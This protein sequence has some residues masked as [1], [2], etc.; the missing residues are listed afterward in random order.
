MDQQIRAHLET[1]EAAPGDA[2]AFQAL[3]EAF[4]KGG[5]FDEL[6]S[7]L[8]AR[9]RVLPAAG[10]AQ[11]LAQA[12]GVALRN[13]ANP[14]RA[15]EL[16]RGLLALD[17]VS[18]PALL[19]LAELAEARQDWAA[20]AEALERRVPLTTDPG[21]SARL[22][23][24]L[25]VIYEER[26]GRRDRAAM[27]F[28]GAVRL[29]AG[30]VEARQRGLEACLGLRRY[31]QAKRLLDTARD[32]GAE[33]PALARDYVRLGATLADQ[34]LFHDVAMDALIEA[35]AIDR[36]T[37]GAAEARERLTALPRRWREEAAALEAAAAAAPRKE[38]A[39]LLLRTAQ[40]QAA[41]APDGVGPAVDLLERAWA[42]APGQPAV[43]ELLERVL[44]E[45]K[46]YG[47]QAAALE[48]LAA[49]TRDRGALVQ[50][51]LAASRLKLVRLGDGAGALAALAR[52]L[53]LDPAC[54]TAALQSFE[55]LADAGR[56]AEA[57][58]VLERHLEATPEKPGHALLRVRAAD[59][60]RSRLGDPARARRHLE[61]A[62][63]A[64]P[65]HAPAAAALVPLLTEGEEWARLAE[66][67]AV[68][69]AGEPD[70]AARVRLQEQLAAVEVER[71]DRPADAFR[72]LSRALTL[73]PHRGSVRSAL[74][75]AARR[76][77]LLPE[78]CR[79]LRAAAMAVG[80]DGP[81][82]RALMQ[83][84]AEL[85]EQELGQPEA[86]AAAW[87]ELA[88][89]DPSDSEVA[90]AVAECET[91]LRA[92]LEELVTLEA[93]HAAATGAARRQTG[94]AL[95]SRLTAAGRGAAAATVWRE[96]QAA[97]ADAADDAESLWGLHA[98][99]EATPGAVAAEERT[100]VLARLAALARG[101]PER[102]QLELER[103]AILVD[104]LGR[105]GEAA[106]VVTGLLSAGGATAQQQQLAVSLLER[107]LARGV[108]PLR[109]ARVLAP[110][111]AAR[112]DARRQVAMLE[113]VARRLPADADP[114]ERARHL[115]DA[116]S[117]RA[118][119]MGDARGALTAAAEALR[120]APNHPEARKRCEQLAHQVGAQAE[121]YAL[122]VAAARQLAGRPD[123]ELVLRRRAAAVAE[124]ELG[125]SDAA[126]EELRRCLVLRPGDP[127]LLATLTRV[128]LVA[129][130]WDDAAE[131]LGERARAAAGGDRAVL[132]GQQ[133][134]VLLERLHRAPEAVEAYRAALVWWRRLAGAGCSPRWRWRS[135]RPATRS[136]R[137]R[138]STSWRPPPTIRPR[139]P[140]PPAR[141]HG[142]RPGWATRPAPWC[143][144]RRR[145]DPIRTTPRPLARWSKRW[146][147][148]S[149]RWSRPPPTPSSRR[150]PPAATSPGGCG[151]SPPGPG[152]TPRRPAGP[153]PG[154]RWRSSTSRR[155][156]RRPRRW[157]PPSRRCGPGRPTPSFAARCAGSPTSTTTPRRRPGSSTRCPR[158]STPPIG[159]WCSGSWA[160][161]A[162]AGSRPVIGRPRP[163]SGCWRSPPRTAARWRRCGGSTAPPGSGPG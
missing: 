46:D 129:E 70:I 90:W 29:D 158:R 136:S 133:G 100:Q 51:H 2:E 132:L 75:E 40:L 79:S 106:G 9:A 124:E 134:E 42:L 114:R 94:S 68:Q 7:L 19:A 12:A 123:D 63:R 149:R 55:Q 144:W 54:E 95:A 152:P 34:A 92:Q 10:A 160:T 61:A 71:L 14:A 20:V 87:R 107:L 122:L 135:A 113:L 1:L 33:R 163:S 45:R 30:L 3:E 93:A 23:L 73:D 39:E 47:G 32:A 13:A 117:I 153:G 102:A 157:R 50:L 91:R 77:R 28:A 72:T 38:A 36:T 6:A 27:R 138:C 67:L 141:A 60:A 108:D 126:V 56:F 44:S 159:S 76:A 128:C 145:F 17:P 74:E 148:P 110:A 41:Y 86:A 104:P 5:R 59:L 48:R 130:R 78:L 146:P 4:R 37:P 21:A 111:Y 156:R 89:L 155:G 161:G 131:L 147:T 85:L 109:I 118:E 52:A 96:L 143:G 15:E 83:R 116:S 35:Q 58:A 22:A 101:S 64:D 154:T 121:L 57:L 112:G 120:A 105:L 151:R 16:Y 8:E 81:V 137:P 53:E 62:L 103:A 127:E 65:G 25:G 139:R 66:V 31:A 43:L 125:A 18:E 88:A 80:D 69:V 142:W 115:L 162:S 150:T 49:V 24:R 84:A 99:L 11:A 82:R 140:G 98:A 26:L 119:R 97:S